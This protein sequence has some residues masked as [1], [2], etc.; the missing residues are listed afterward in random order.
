MKQLIAGFLLVGLLSPSLVA[1][2]QIPTLYNTGVQPNVLSNVLTN[3]MGSNGAITD[4]QQLRLRV[5][6][7]WI[8]LN[9]LYAI[10]KAREA[11]NGGT[12]P[13]GTTTP[14]INPPQANNK[15][16]VDLKGLKSNYNVGEDLAFSLE[17][18]KKENGPSTLNFTSCQVAYTITLNTGAKPIIYNSL[19]AQSCI[20][21]TSSV[22]LPKTWPLS[23]TAELAPGNYKLTAEV[24]GYGKSDEW[25]FNV[26]RPGDPSI[27]LTSP[28]SNIIWATSTAKTVTW[29]TVNASSTDKVDIIL[30]TPGQAYIPLM[31]SA[32][33]PNDGSQSVTLPDNLLPGTYHL[34]LRLTRG[35]TLADSNQVQVI[36]NEPAQPVGSPFI[37]G[38]SP[39]KGATGTPVLISGN[40]FFLEQSVQTFLPPAANSILFDGKVLATNVTLVNG[41]LPFTIPDDVTPGLKAVAVKRGS[42]SS[43]TVYFE[44]LQYPVQ[45]SVTTIIDITAPN[46]N[47]EPW[48]LGTTKSITWE[49]TPATGAATKVNIRL[50]NVETNQV[51]DIK[52]GA[53]NTES[54]SWKVG[55]LAGGGTAAV[56][57]YKFRVCPVGL[58]NCDRGDYNVKL[59]APTTDPNAKT[60]LNGSSELAATASVLQGLINQLNILLRSR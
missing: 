38:L 26:K 56:G 28:D 39:V 12:P 20:Q 4:I 33:T 24:I 9:N 60:S 15:I 51:Q 45:P 47:N 1:A 44:V 16:K 29:S 42:V 6:Q 27:T 19:S 48:T 5:N 14:P 31:G 41:K 18:K 21:A 30:I 35:A 13:T 22:S 25:H 3:E 58:G 36:I 40:N 10:I 7:L 17:A 50:I 59:V 23:Y 32:G 8:I 54:Y 53:D 55:E 34:F 37:T 2:Q 57:R 49:S 46:T 11:A 43:N 52:L